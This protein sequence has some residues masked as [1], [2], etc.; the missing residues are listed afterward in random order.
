MI[1][2]ELVLAVPA[3]A[4]NQYRSFWEH[5][6]FFRDPKGLMGSNI[7]ATYGH[8]WIPR[9]EADHMPEFKQIIP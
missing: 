6:K 4:V 1:N 7:L 5:T 8:R 9:A 2:D 3:D